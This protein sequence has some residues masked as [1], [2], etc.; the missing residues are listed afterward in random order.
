VDLK[1]SPIGALHDIDTGGVEIEDRK[2]SR[3]R[4]G[5]GFAARSRH[6]IVELGATEKGLLAGNLFRRHRVYLSECCV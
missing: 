4:L 5:E 2:P 6:G 1:S 3:K